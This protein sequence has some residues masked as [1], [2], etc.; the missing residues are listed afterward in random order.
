MMAVG[1]IGDQEVAVGLDTMAQGSF[2][3]EELI[4]LFPDLFP[5]V[6]ASV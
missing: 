1:A 2:I 4:H 6:L 5:P 3:D